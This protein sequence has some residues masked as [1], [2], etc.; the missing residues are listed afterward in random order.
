MRSHHELDDAGG[1][2]IVTG[3]VLCILVYGMVIVMAIAGFS[4]AVPLVVLPPVVLGLMA[5][6]NLLG[7]GRPRSRSASPRRPAGPTGSEE[8]SRPR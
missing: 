7:G 3:I 8:P 6:N 1:V 4:A 2:W 5:A